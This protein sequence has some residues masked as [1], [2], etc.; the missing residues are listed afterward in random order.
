VF[1]GNTHI[2]EDIDISK[3]RRTYRGRKTGNGIRKRNPEFFQPDP[4]IGFGSDCRDQTQPT[5]SRAGIWNRTRN[6]KRRKKRKN[7]TA[8]DADGSRRNF[9]P[10]FL[11]PAS[12]RCGNHTA[13]RNIKSRHCI[14]SDRVG[15]RNIGLRKKNGKRP[16]AILYRGRI[17]QKSCREMELLQKRHGCK[18]HMGTG[19]RNLVLHGCV[20]VHGIGLLAAGKWDLVL[21]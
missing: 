15:S 17:P 16:D 1:P 8:S 4:E 20:R 7:R 5:G 2:G 10:L 13:G 18:K 6:R 3:E 12:H 14:R 11:L 9:I 21:F 19:R